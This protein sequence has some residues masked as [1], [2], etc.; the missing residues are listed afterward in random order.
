MRKPLTNIQELL[1][2]IGNNDINAYETL[3][4]SLC[5]PLYNFALSI[6]QS[7]QQAEEIV[8][9]VF[10]KIWQARNTLAEIRNIH[11]YLYTSVRNRAFDYLHKERR[12]GVSVFQPED[13]DDITIELKSPLDYCISAD[14]MQKINNAVNQLPPQCK[15]IFKLIKEEGLSYKQVAEIMQISPLTVRNQLAIAVRKM[16]ES[17]PA[18]IHGRP[19]ADSK[20]NV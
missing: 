16:G 5:T 17:L 3:Y 11:V 4:H 8:S 6:I 20:K 1:V 2:R 19:A 7:R 14:L 12:Q 10:I 15:M 9:D 18:Y 13:W